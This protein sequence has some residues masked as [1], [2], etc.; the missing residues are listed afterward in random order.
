MKQTQ[1]HKIDPAVEEVLAS[2]RQIMS[3]DLNEG[4]DAQGNEIISFHGPKKSTSRKQTQESSDILTLTEMITSDGSVVSLGNKEAEMAEKVVS[5]PEAND[6]KGDAND[7]AA[8]LDLSHEEGFI[9][10]E[11]TSLKVVSAEDMASLMSPEAVAQS[12]DAFNDLNKLTET[13]AKK[14]QS[15]SFGAQTI[16]EL[17]REMLRPLLKE[18]LDSHL[19]SLVKWLV[20]EKIEQMIREKREN[21]DK[22]S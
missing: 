11:D 16:D 2:I 4:A 15:E 19:P 6:K 18:W 7:S 22:A 20:A 5:K 1:P 14:I 3:I 17:M 21:S 9:Q 12:K 13:M 8:P 10:A